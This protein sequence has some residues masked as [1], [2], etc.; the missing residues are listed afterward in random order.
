MSRARSCIGILLVSYTDGHTIKAVERDADH[1]FATEGPDDMPAHVKSAL[2]GASVTI[3]IRD[4]KLATG[5]QRPMQKVRAVID[6][7]G[8]H[9]ARYLVPG[10]SGNEASTTRGCDHS[11]RKSIEK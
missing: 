6:N 3:P 7:Q 8:R 2:I 9:L 1:V 11:R 4:G 10:V 5:E